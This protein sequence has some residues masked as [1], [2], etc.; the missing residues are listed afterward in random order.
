MHILGSYSRPIES[1]T[2]ELNTVICVFKSP[3]GDS[4]AHSHLKTSALEDGKD[5]SEKK[6]GALM[7]QSTALLAHS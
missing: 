5:T 7:K 1:N 6:P 3:P 2:L 4:D